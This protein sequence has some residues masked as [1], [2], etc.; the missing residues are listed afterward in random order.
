[1]TGFGAGTARAAGLDVRVELR[2]VNHRGLDIRMRLPPAF[3]DLQAELQADLRERVRRGHV[4]VA[5]DLRRAADAAPVVRVDVAL[6]LAWR[7]AIGE[8][9]E[10]LADAPGR[11]GQ[12][13]AESAPLAL[14]LTQPG[15][16]EVVRPED[17]AEI[18]ADAIRVAWQAAVDALL[19]SRAAEG[20]RLVV[21]LRE[22]IDAI[23][24]ARA[25]IAELAALALDAA[26]S[27]IRA[28][29]DE[30]VGHSVAL[31][32]G[33]IET[34]IVLIADRS[35]VTEELVRLAGHLVAFRQSCDDEDGGRKLGFLV[36]E[37]LR[38]TNTIGSKCSDLAMT[39]Q[40]VAIK[41]ELE[42]VREQVSN[43]A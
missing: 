31:D 1:M 30:L 24:T 6:G 15:V 12:T 17:D 32:R 2:S 28:R 41:V 21:D 36:Q 37:L 14:V 7:N 11:A 40:V 10:A 39:E 26:R 4:D 29:I 8:L 5:I 27:R 35:D 42:K 43:L 38:E 18:A 16:I 34:E 23:D 9:A 20:A 33:R 25:R 22:R 13:N 3:A 19:A